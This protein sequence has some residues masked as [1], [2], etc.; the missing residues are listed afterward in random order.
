MGKTHKPTATIAVLAAVVLAALLSS[1]GSSNNTT[2]P[3]AN[4]TNPP[5]TQTQADNT[6][7]TATS[8]QTPA[9]TSTTS[10]TAAGK[11]PPH[12]M[13]VERV[14]VS[15]P[16]INTKDELDPRY[17]CTGQNTPP[18]LHWKGIPPGTSELMLEIIKLKPVDHQ[19]YYAWTITHINPHT[20]GIKPG[21]TP[22]GAITGQ[23]GAGQATYNLC[24]PKG[25]TETYV[26]AL[27]ALPHPLHS[28]PAY[29]PHTQREKAEQD[30][31]YVGYNHFTT[32]Q[33]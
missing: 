15:S 16:A 1:C 7:S 11:P 13:T 9:T 22:P 2:K 25:H 29:N 14:E 33:H 17:T 30:A 8:S 3:A 27:F 21:E 24:P 19:L 32:T 4:N 18:P 26:I 28:K 31:N 20:K 10:T 5:T 23:N 6:S 12:E